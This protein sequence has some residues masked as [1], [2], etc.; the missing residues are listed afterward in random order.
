MD[1][2]RTVVG[3]PSIDQ[4]TA[5]RNS[6]FPPRPA[7]PAEE[8]LMS[9]TV[10]LLGVLLLGTLVPAA[11]ASAQQQQDS[12]MLLAPPAITGW[13]EGGTSGVAGL[14]LVQSLADSG[15]YVSRTRFAPGRGLGPHQHT[16]TTTITV[17]QGRFH[18]GIGSSV[19][20]S[21]VRGY[22]PGSFLVIPAG[23]P[24]YEWGEGETVIQLSGV[25][26]LGYT[27]I[28]INHVGER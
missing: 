10:V 16:R 2:I 28:E 7:P 20:S 19:D 12:V 25:G 27:R 1:A 15:H 18:L 5:V 22:P 21:A 8:L 3:T 6:A 13:R 26:P 23:V 14:D 17:L 11:T 24:H 9:T 4:L